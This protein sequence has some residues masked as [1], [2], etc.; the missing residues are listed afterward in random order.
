MDKQPPFEWYRKRRGEI[1]TRLEALPKEIAEVEGVYQE[2]LKVLDNQ[3]F[4]WWNKLTG[5]R[6]DATLKSHWDRRSALQEELRKL[7]VEASNLERAVQD[8]R[9]IKKRFMDARLARNAAEE[10]KRVQAGIHEKL[11]DSARDNLSGEFSRANFFIQVKDYRRGNAVDNYFRKIEEQVF[12]CFNHCCVF[13]GNSDKLTFD[14]YGIS[15]N[16][17]GNFAL[18]TSDKISIRLNIVVLCRSCNAAKS[19]GGHLTFFNDEQRD[20]AVS[21][22]RTL[23]DIL[24]S[25]KL[26]LKLID[27]WSR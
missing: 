26:F 19:Q 23:L 8:A 20:R 12:Q 15:K 18:I 14:H 11:C 6:M 25:D 2:H 1:R 7:Q 22:Q 5:N 3:P 16:E 4:S 10:R 21:C 13:C 27:K 9:T 17:G 24:L